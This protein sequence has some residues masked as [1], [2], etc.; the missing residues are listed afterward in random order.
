MARDGGAPRFFRPQ[1]VDVECE[2]LTSESESADGKGAG[3]LN[4]FGG[5]AVLLA[6]SGAVL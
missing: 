6:G 1:G 5:I 4:D 2:V 3:I